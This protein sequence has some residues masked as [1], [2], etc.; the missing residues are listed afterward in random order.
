MGLR[1]VYGRAG[2]G[3]SLY[4]IKD[5]IKS[6]NSD[7]DK[8]DRSLIFLVPEQFTVQAEKLL[9]DEP[10]CGNCLIRA[11]VLSFRRMSK[12]VANDI[13]DV[14]TP[15]IDGPG[16]KMILCRAVE[17]CGSS[18]ILFKNAS[19]RP[20]LLDEIMQII[21]EAGRYD[22]S[23]SRM[24][25]VA[26]EL[27]EGIP[28]K[29]KL[30]EIRLIYDKY[31]EILHERYVDSKDLMDLLAE[32][33]KEY[34]PYRNM[35]VWID[36]FFG[37]TPQEYKIISEILKIAEEVTITLCCGIPENREYEEAD[38]LSSVYK[39]YDRLIKLAGENGITVEKPV[40]LSGAD[41]K[42]RHINPALAHFEREYGVYP[43]KKY[44][45]ETCGIDVYAA[46]NI[47]TETEYAACAIK[48][49]CRDKGLRYR[50]IAVIAKNTQTYGPICA[51][52]FEKNEIPFF[53]DDKSS[54]TVH[55]LARLIMSAIDAVSENFSYRTIFTYLKSGLLSYDQEILDVIE[56]HVLAKNI[57]TY[58]KWTD[59]EKWIFSD[60]GLEERVNRERKELLTP[61]IKFK[62]A[63]AGGRTVREKAEALYDFT[64]DINI[65]EIIMNRDEASSDGILKKSEY[66][67]IWNGF[68]EVLDKLVEALGDKKMSQTAFTNILKAGIGDYEVG[69]IPTTLDCV[70]IGSLDRTK[71]PGIKALVFMG[72]NEGVVPGGP[73]KEG[74]LTDSE[75]VLLRDHNV[76]LAA[77]SREQA[78]LEEFQIYAALMSPSEYLYLSYIL[79]D[80]EGKPKRASRI[81][82][83]ALGMF[84]R[85]KEKSDV[86]TD[87]IYQRPMESISSKEQCFS[88]YLNY[89]GSGRKETIWDAAG[90]YFSKDPIYGDKLQRALKYKKSRTERICLSADRAEKLFGTEVTTSISR[91][92]RYN[93]CPYSFY[94]DYGLKLKEREVFSFSLREAGSFVHEILE[95][96]GSGISEELSDREVE[97]IIKKTIYDSENFSFRESARSEFLARRMG[98]MV[99]RV[100]SIITRQIQDGKFKPY[101]FESECNMEIALSG[102]KKAVL[103]GKIDRID[104]Y[105]T[106][107]GNYYRVIDYKTGNK[108]FDFSDVYYGTAVQLPVYLDAV[109]KNEPEA[110][111]AGG[112]YFNIKDAFTRFSA[113]TGPS[114]MEA[115]Q[116]KSFK[117]S[118]ILLADTDIVRAM[119]NNIGSS[120]F[121]IPAGIKKDGNF[122]ASSWVATKE[123]FD[124]LF[125]H[126]EKVIADSIESYTS[127]NIAPLPVK[128]GKNKTP[129]EYCKYFA[130]C[131]FDPAAGDKYRTMK[132]IDKK[133]IWEILKGENKNDN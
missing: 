94:A 27:P 4:C 71:N 23:G 87:E 17:E 72:I 123:Q 103:T 132:K 106:E 129:C 125:S 5:I 31:E 73:L 24:E 65:P 26:L 61:L 92:E 69:K 36:G 12:R 37:F 84:P 63:F 43:V 29:Q 115:A 19:E 39:T 108:E 33:L 102:N 13:M 44:D 76:T 50:D 62:E 131:G 82:G 6:I 124:C 28:L 130:V 34:G 21:D 58:K 32:N 14:K 128:S 66:I 8:K 40:Y 22:F 126:S 79:K 100:A 98:K 116:R 133:Y 93:L 48:S 45:R 2:A 53:I 121:I 80:D 120:S 83:R 85:I 25:Q 60:S 122:S 97:E 81:I 104:V 38:F 59:D 89:I 35:K 114:E 9:L 11:D 16:R 30:T 78:Y 49:L 117:F 67:N 64:V 101:K 57:N 46:K 88:K 86:L 41:G 75:R 7:K 90:A 105:S 74:I 77:E 91:V 1:I 55:P 15:V 47:Y 112:L 99:K 109:V 52:I 111:P 20:G 95:R 113:D 56:N 119:D 96:I 51:D 42:T 10:E 70:Q 127:G 18:L 110:N 54:I 118:G 68:L 3:K 107:E